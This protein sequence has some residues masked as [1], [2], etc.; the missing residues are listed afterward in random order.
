M[1]N[2]EETIA[3]VIGL[4]LLGIVL[5]VGSMTL[6]LILCGVYALGI[7]GVPRYLKME[8]VEKKIIPV[9]LWSAL[10]MVVFL[11]FGL[12]GLPGLADLD[13]A[14]DAWTPDGLTKLSSGV[15]DAVIYPNY[16]NNGSDYAESGNYYYVDPALYTDHYHALQV[17]IDE[18]AAGLR[19]PDGNSAQVATVSSG[20]VTFSDVEVVT[21]QN[22]GI[23]Y[24]Y[25]S[26]PA[27]AEWPSM[28]WKD[29]TVSAPDDD[30]S[31]N[32]HK[33]TGSVLRIAKL[34]TLDSYDTENNDIAQYLYKGS[35]TTAEANKLATF[36]ARPQ[37]EGT[38]IRDTYFYVETDST[39]DSQID[40]IKIAGTVYQFS[41]WIDISD[42]SATYREAKESKQAT[43]NTLYAVAVVPAMEYV[44]STAGTPDSKGKVE[45]EIQWDFPSMAV[46]TSMMT[47][48]YGVPQG[49][50]GADMHYSASANPL[51]TFNATTQVGASTAWT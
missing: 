33:L 10:F 20:S 3:L 28:L 47:Y 36:W 4:F 51:L 24:I 42:A 25:D 6:A 46:N 12:L 7:I 49:A 9:N 43:G 11:G 5:F 14:K 41:S 8:V 32:N 15:G 37:T 38:V 1:A 26:T 35:T 50:G 16:W 31:D 30:D 17:Y 39:S 29:I 23:V 19:G 2:K 21:G 40:H 27:A 34:G 22:L 18:G 13:D 44:S 45:I 48:I